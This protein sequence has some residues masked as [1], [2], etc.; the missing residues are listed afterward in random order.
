M[1]LHCNHY[2]S[3]LVAWL[4]RGCPDGLRHSW[5]PS[6]R[7]AARRPAPAVG[8]RGLRPL[9]AAAAATAGDLPSELAESALTDRH[10]TTV[11]QPVRRPF[12]LRKR[13]RIRYAF[14]ANGEVVLRR[15]CLEPAEADPALAP[16]LALLEQAARM[17]RCS[18][19][20]LGP[21]EP[22]R[23]LRDCTRL[24]STPRTSRE[25]RYAT[26]AERPHCLV[27]DRSAAPGSC[28]FPRPQSHQ[29]DRAPAGERDG[30]SLNCSLSTAASGCHHALGGP[31]RAS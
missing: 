2:G 20:A 31:V 19:S 28:R 1:G 10:Q 15:V 13:D 18:A 24:S 4:C 30:L 17:A 27:A 7:A 29:P 26:A 6:P 14:R 25:A 5:L 9:P 3:I 16:F 22:A 23:F 21:W 12:G 8:Q 11:P